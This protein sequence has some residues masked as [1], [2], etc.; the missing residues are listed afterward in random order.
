[1]G[2]CWYCYW[3]WP[4]V[5]RDIFSDAKFALGGDENPLIFGPSH[6][7]WEEE[8]FDDDSIEWCINEATVENCQKYELPPFQMGVISASLKRLLAVQP[9]VRACEPQDYDG[10]NPENYPPDPLLECAYRL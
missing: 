7:V 3:G 4:R 6:I 1:M 5:V 8:N 10:E 9:H 2:M